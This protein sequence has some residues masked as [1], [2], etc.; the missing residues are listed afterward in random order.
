MTAIAT[1]FPGVQTIHVARA[2][3]LGLKVTVVPAQAF[4]IVEAP[5]QTP[6][7]VSQ[8]GL[9]MAPAPAKLVRPTIVLSEPI[10]PFAHPLPAWAMKIMGFLRLVAPATRPRLQ[11]IAY[12]GGEVRA[13]M[14]KGPTLILGTLNLLPEKAVA[15]NTMLHSVPTKTLDRATYLDLSV[16]DRPALGNGTVPAMPSSTSTKG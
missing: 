12:Q 5:G 15:L 11:N 16:P 4:A 10:P 3:P 6:V 9:V 1:R 7:V 2:W 13:Q 8:R 14:T